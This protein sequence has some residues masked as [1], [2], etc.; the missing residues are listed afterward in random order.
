MMP[1]N[2]TASWSSVQGSAWGVWDLSG[3][4]VFVSRV[5]KASSMAFPD[6]LAAVLEGLRAFFLGGMLDNVEM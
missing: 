3:V 2:R 1:L 4:F 5:V 6:G